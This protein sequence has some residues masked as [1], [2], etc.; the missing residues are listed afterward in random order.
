[1]R[2]TQM[3]LAGLISGAVVGAVAALLFAPTSGKELQD[4]F[5]SQWENVVSEARS[6]ADSRRA[7]LEARRMALMKGEA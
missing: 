6:A 4:R 1:M 7:E 2:S 3:F 5:K